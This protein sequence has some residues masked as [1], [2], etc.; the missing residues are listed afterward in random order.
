M[1]LDFRDEARFLEQFRRNYGGHFWGAICTFPQPAEGLV[2]HDVLVETFEPGESVA[3]FLKRT[4]ERTISC[5][6]RLDNG[7]WVAEG[8][9]GAGW[10]E[11]DDNAMRSSVALCGIQSYLKMMIW[12]NLIHADLHPGNVLIRMEEIGWMARLQRWLV[13]GDTSA[14][15]PHIVFLDAGLAASFPEQIASS[16]HHF[17]DA[18]VQT[19]GPRL[20][21]AILG[22]APSQPNVADEDAFI[23]EVAA[24]C[25][26]QKSEFVVGAGNPGKN[27]RSYMESVRNHNVVLDPTVMVAVMSMMVL[28]GWQC[29]LDPEIS[30]MDCLSEAIGGGIFGRMTQLN[31]WVQDAKERINKALGRE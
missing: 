7:K 20:G 15:V 13:L 4:G 12:D 10:E 2:A 6:R 21:R 16:V 19:D 25:E 11:N 30:V 26:Q 27:I 28:E 9:E 3:K 24:K 22:L 8:A 31:Q 18:I 17:F 1:Q 23:R 14:R 5:W 29:R